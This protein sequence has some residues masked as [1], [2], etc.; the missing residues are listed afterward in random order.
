MNA[1]QETVDARHEAV[2]QALANIRFR[3]VVFSGKGGVGKS[4]VAVNLACALAGSDCS[5]GLLDADITG[6]NIPHMMGI[7]DPAEA[8]GTEIQPQEAYGVKVV[9]LASMVPAEAPVIWR[10][11]M[12]SNAIEQL[13]GDTAWGSLDALIIDLPPGTGDE[14]L[15]I[16]QRTSP[17][18]AIVVTTPQE[19]SLMDARRAVNMAKELKVPRIALLENMSGFVCP[20]CGTRLDL[21]GSGTAQ[22]DAARLEV[23]YL[24]QIPIDPDLR[25]GSDQGDPIVVSHPESPSAQAF[26][27]IVNHLEPDVCSS[28]PA[29]AS[30]TSDQKDTP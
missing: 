16:A 17:Q 12:R 1:K 18:M 23:Q 22:S 25:T 6:P 20:H 15:T 21:F 8:I 13:L 29:A 4:T 3:I 24:G 5:V 2:A 26:R 27:S 10:G 9:S 11:P 19:V 28:D 30:S 14:V 7:H